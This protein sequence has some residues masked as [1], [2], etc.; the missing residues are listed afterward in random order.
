MKAARYSGALS[1]PVPFRFVYEYSR[2]HPEYST[3]LVMRVTKGYETLLD[4]CCKTDNPAECYGNAVGA[5]LCLQ[6]TRMLGW[7][8]SQENCVEKLLQK[9]RQ[10]AFGETNSRGS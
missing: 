7:Y 8:L 2:R 1:A 6:M 4:K 5:K 3:E 9:S 10:K